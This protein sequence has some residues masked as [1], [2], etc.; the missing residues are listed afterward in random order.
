MRTGNLER[1]ATSERHGRV[2]ALSPSQMG[3]YF[4]HIHSRNSVYLEQLTCEIAGPLDIGIACACLEALVDRHSILRTVFTIKAPRGLRQ[5]AL[6]LTSLDLELVDLTQVDDQDGAVDALLRSEAALNLD[7][8]RSASR[9]KLLRLGAE[10]FVFVWTYH[11]ILLDSWTLL[12]LQQQFTELYLQALQN[13]PATTTASYPQYWEYV[14]WTQACDRQR[15]LEYWRGYLGKAKS[16][17]PMSLPSETVAENTAVTAGELPASLTELLAN[18][19]ASSRTSAASVFLA[20]W[21]TYSLGR[22]GRSENIVGCVYANR[23]IPLKAAGKI[24]GLFA[25]SLPIRSQHGTTATQHIAGIHR[26]MMQWPRY[27]WISLSEIMASA[28]MT[29]YDISSVVNFSIDQPDIENEHSRQLPIRIGN[30]RY[31]EQAHFPV[32]EV[33]LS[34]DRPRLSVRYDRRRDTYDADDMIGGLERILTAFRD[35]PDLPLGQL[36]RPKLESG[37]LS[38]IDFA[39]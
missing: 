34:G 9:C 37:A 12:L 23:L 4:H 38:A 6:P 22:S 8:S 2:L 27:A 13:R 36:A 21:S 1:G 31:R 5:V 15:T 32:L 16:S 33:F 30:I 35:S 18:L 14:A 24:A 3:M 17:F 11:H 28:G 20:A 7:L 29:V 25:N 39:F 26:E 19:Q 10:R